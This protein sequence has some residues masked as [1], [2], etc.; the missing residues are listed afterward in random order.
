[1]LAQVQRRLHTE[2]RWLIVAGVVVVS[3]FGSGMSW[4]AMGIFFSP[5][6]EEFGWGRGAYSIAMS[7]YLTMLTVSSVP[8]GR[9]VDR[10]GPRKVMLASTLATG[11]AWGLVSQIGHVGRH[12]ALW[13]LYLFYGILAIASAGVGSV[14][15]ST[16]IA[17]WFTKARGLAM[18]LSIVGF[19][20]PGVIA[21]PLSAPFIAA[22]G[23]RTLAM[24]L[25]ALSW[26]GSIPFI[27]WVLR[28]VPPSPDQPIGQV[29]PG[30]SARDALRMTPLWIIGICYLLAQF[31]SVA[32]QMHAIPFLMDRGLTRE[33]ASNIWGVLAL[34]G[35]IGKVGL[36]YA[37]DK[38]SPKLVLL[39]S[40]LLQVISLI[41]VL[42]W[43]SM[44]TA[45]L[46]ALLFGLGMGGQFSS[47]PLLVGEYFGLRA[48]GTIAGAV[49]LFTL[50][51][52]AAG[53]PVAGFLFDFTGSYTL[54]YTLFIVTYVLAMAVLLFL[55]RSPG[56]MQTPGESSG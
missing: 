1:V 34:A 8:V 23:W 3:F 52:I 24:T 56:E 36:G 44:T 20:L 2:Y 37:A 7:L 50:P 42:T 11:L 12:S 49:W 25:G 45:W 30:I 14:P 19:G 31:G 21:V 22:Y 51:G 53:Q 40:M 17:R 39:A 4:Y 32:V 13:Q 41:M 6:V 10:W 47:R 28:D 38:I 16:V 35:V 27:V 55:R 15:A 26:L 5:L 46:F 48:F 18:G 9:M 54:A 33:V 43:P 29:L